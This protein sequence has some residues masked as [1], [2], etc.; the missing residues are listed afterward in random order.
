MLQEVDTLWQCARVP[1]LKMW[2]KFS[3]YKVFST[4]SPDIWLKLR[5]PGTYAAIIDENQTPLA[6]FPQTL[7]REVSYCKVI[8]GSD[9]NDFLRAPLIHGLNR[10]PSPEI[11]LFFRWKCSN[12]ACKC[13]RWPVLLQCASRTTIIPITKPETWPKTASTYAFSGITLRPECHRPK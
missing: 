13:W 6:R 9:G 10:T 7:Y 11:Y 8:K 12:F 3:V 4:S 5:L 1:V 2:N